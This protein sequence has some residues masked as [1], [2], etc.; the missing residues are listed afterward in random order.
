MSKLVW[1]IILIAL[2]LTTDV[3]FLK[4]IL[5]AIICLVIFLG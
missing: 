5:V 3:N 4:T 1:W 2:V